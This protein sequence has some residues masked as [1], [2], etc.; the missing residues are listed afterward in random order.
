[1]LFQQALLGQSFHTHC[2]DGKAVCELLMTVSDTCAQ[3]ISE[4]CG[5]CTI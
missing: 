4:Q 3:P 2:S 1:M 5:L